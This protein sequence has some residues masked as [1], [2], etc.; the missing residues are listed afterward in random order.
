V[1]GMTPEAKSGQ[2]LRKMFTYVAARTIMAEIE[3]Y[4][5][6]GGSASSHPVWTGLQEALLADGGASNDDFVEKLISH[7]DHEMRMAA[8]RIIEV[9]ASFAEDVFNWDKMRAAAIQE[10]EMDTQRAQSQFGNGML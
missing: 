9:R 1:G 3:G 4:D 6:E 7:P 2:M 8:I 5:N 10:I